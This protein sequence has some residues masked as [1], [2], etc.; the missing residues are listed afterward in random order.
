MASIS[1]TTVL[2]CQ[3]NNALPNVFLMAC[4]IRPTTFFQKP[5]YH[6]ALLGIKCHG[7]PMLPS[8]SNNLCRSSTAARKVE[9]LLDV[10]ILEGIDFWLEICETLTR[11][12]LHYDYFKVECTCVSTP[13]NANVHIPFSYSNLQKFTLVTVN[14]VTW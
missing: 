5:P 4:F 14:G 7:V 12:F 13:K 9:A 2:R 1:T 6:G 3:C 11:M 10:Y 8:D